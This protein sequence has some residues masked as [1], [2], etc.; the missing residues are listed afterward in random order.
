MPAR[1][2]NDSRNQRIIEA[3]KAGAI[4]TPELFRALGIKTKRDRKAAESALSKLIKAQKVFDDDGVLKA[5]AEVDNSQ[6]PVGRITITPMGF[7]FVTPRDGGPET[8][9]IFIPEKFVG[10]AL[11]GDLV[12]VKTFEERPENHVE[13]KGPVGAVVEIVES[14]RKSVVGQLALGRD[15]F[16]VRPLSKRMPRDIPFKGELGDCDRGDWVKLSL[17]RSNEMN[18]KRRSSSI[19]RIGTTGSIGDDLRAIASEFDLRP[20]YSLEQELRAGT[21]EPLNIERE[22]LTSLFCL[23]IDPHDA[24]DFDDA[25][26]I[27]K[28]D[29]ADEAWLGVHISDL[30]TW[31]PSGSEI[32]TCAADR[33]FTAYL[34]GNT[35]PMLPKTLT[36]TASLV[37]GRVEPAHTVMMRVSLQTGEILESRRT[38]SSIIVSERITF[39]QAQEFIDGEP[40]ESS[41]ELLSCMPK[42]INL[43]RVMRRHRASMEGFLRVETSDVRVLCDES[44]KKILGLR[45]ETQRESEELVEEFMLAANSIVARE[46]VNRSIPGVF[47]IHPEPDG[48]RMREFA[49][50]MRDVFRIRT[51]DLA[52][53]R[54]ACRRFLEF[55]PNDD[56]RQII[57]SAFVR[58][59]S[60]ASYA[61]SPALHYGLGKNIYCHFTSPI[62]RYTDLTVHQQLWAVDSG[63]KTRPVEVMATVAASCTEKEKNTDEAYFAANDR[64]KLHHLKSIMRSTGAVMFDGYVRQVSGSGIQAD[65]P[66]FGLS[67]FVP[68]DALPGFSRKRG[69]L[70]AARGHSRHKPGDFISLRLDRIDI[71]KGVAYFKPA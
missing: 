57:M 61:E 3:L 32:D 39:D 58:S 43:F 31:V 69:C 55:V 71:V 38:H 48:R 53:D 1:E 9:D 41:S 68:I 65:I 35:L 60:R 6:L 30:A 12:S 11:D 47:R 62:R 4:R 59:L 20:P 37:K 34:P 50:L 24:K 49:Q 29:S 63:A 13:G 45:R 21:I 66:E 26:S 54:E 67:A 27:S 52:S 15:G 22:D 64:L 25:V 36:R 16:V 42:L 44:T 17:D 14:R 51:G 18:S 56:R 23:T 46:M 5:A 8:E 10:E 19:E 33:G 7:G 40:G 70:V 2:K 28:G